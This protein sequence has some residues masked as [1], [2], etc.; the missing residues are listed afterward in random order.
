MIER[1]VAFSVHRRWLVLVAALLLTVA[2]AVTAA[3]LFRINTD[4]ER[5]ITPDVPWRQDE[6]QF[7]KT[8]PQRSNLLVAVIDGQTPE[9]AEEAA[10]RLTQA[11]SSRK[12]LLPV[13]YRPD[14]GP[15]FDKNGLLLMPQKDLEQTTEKLIQQQGL[16]G[17]LAADPSLRGI[18]QAMVMGAQGVKAGQAKPDD[19][20]GPMGQ[21]KDVFDKVLKGEPAQL[22]WQL[23]LAGGKAEPSDLRRFVIAQPVLDYDALQPGEKAT[24]LIRETARNLGLT[25][26][27]G[28]RVRLTGQVAV[29]D[30]EFAT[31]ADDAGLNYSVTGGAIVLFL[32]LALRSGSL[33]IAVLITTFAGLIVTAALGLLMVGEL[34]PISVAFA[35]LFVGLGI[36]FGIQFAV[37]YRAD[38]F[39]ESDLV[40][41]IRSAARGVGWSL[42]LAAVSLLAGFFSFLPT[43]FRGVSELGL[44]AGVGMIVAYLASLTMLPALIAVLRPPGEKQEVGTASMASVD[45]WI[46]ANRKLVLVLTGLVTVAGLPLLYWLPFDSNPMHLRSAKV[47][48]VATYLDLTKDP[49]TS[50]NTIDVVVPN[51]DAIAPMVKKLMALPS[52]AGVIDIDTFVPADQDQKLATIED[53]A[54][55]MGPVLNP[56]RVAPA[57]NDREVVT[58]IR[59]AVTA[60]RGISQGAQG[61]ANAAGPL[62]TIQGFT[63]TLDRLAGAEPSVREAAAN[64]VVPNLKALL[65]RL[66][67]LLAPAKITLENLPAQIRSDWVAADGKAR[68]EVQPKGNSNDNAVLRRF[69][70]EVLSVAPHAT[71]APVATTR[72]SHTILGAFIEAGLLALLS[73]FIILSV[74]LRRPWDV[75]MALG[76]LVLA[77][78]WTLEA[79]YLIGMPLNFANIIALPLMLAVGVAF[80]IYY[81]IAWRAGV[82]D[83]LA[84]S[85]TRAIFFSAL[86]TGT[87]FGSLVLSSHPG[88]ASMG[89]LLA[90]SLFFTLVAAFF[91]V[92]AFLG[93]PPKQKAKDGVPENA[94]RRDPLIPA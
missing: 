9:Q 26:A 76:P 16:L 91:I 60:L 49:K 57:P 90:L 78:L 94:A 41:A 61:A 62:A 11:L 84:S 44:I 87:A 22:S 80:H 56:P 82:A 24:Q 63:D 2:S 68:I 89:K 43:D 13:V 37:R 67:S 93:P 70:K 69:S 85:L 7:E 14:G 86:T 28:V 12:D 33:V 39:A 18:M 45:H 92:P 31:L 46:L 54:Q 77:T 79:L 75:A 35:A 3:H 10:N 58:A 51:R 38:R 34:N 52:V 81:V 48:S 36:D 4:V 15:F 88:T 47:E 40:Q 55:V 73:I 29:A 83:M 42:T 23:L 19:L 27:N 50:P 6:I 5:L 8:F 20:V 59:N 21:M 1:L 74:A 30:D 53:A 71:G 64:A 66:R 32:W 25:E 65:T 17:P 72:S